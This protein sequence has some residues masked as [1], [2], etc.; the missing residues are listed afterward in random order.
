MDLIPQECLSDETGSFFGSFTRSFSALPR[1]AL[2]KTTTETEEQELETKNEEDQSE[3]EHVAGD[4]REE[5]TKDGETKGDIQRTNT[6]D[7]RQNAGNEATAHTVHW[8]NE[9]VSSIPAYI[10]R[11]SLMIVLV[12]PSDHSDRPDEICDYSNWRRRGWCRLELAG[13]ALARTNVRVMI[14]KVR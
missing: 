6:S 1:R 11:S 14:V 13:T 8:L 2:T 4:G 12:P 3:E 7:H 9:A 5:T 10:E